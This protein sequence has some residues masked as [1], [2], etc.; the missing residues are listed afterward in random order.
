ME[1]ANPPDYRS[2]DLIE[3]AETDLQQEQ[4]YRTAGI[5]G[6]VAVLALGG[7]LVLLNS[8]NRVDLLPASSILA[9][10]LGPSD[11]MDLASGL[12]PSPQVLSYLRPLDTIYTTDSVYLEV[13]LTRQDVTVHQR[14][15]GSRSFLISSG[16]PFISEGMSTPT[17]IFTVQGMTPMAISKQ[18]NNARLHHWIG[19]QGGV[20]FHGLDGSGYYGYLGKRPSSHGCMRMSREEISD[21]FR[22]VHPG[23]LITVHYGEP[24][25]VIAF[26]DVGDTAGA[27]LIDS[28]SVFNRKLG[29]ER[30]KTLLDGRMWVD[31]QPRLVHLARQRL[32]WGMSMADARKIPKQQIP[33]RKSFGVMRQYLPSMEPDLSHTGISALHSGLARLQAD[34]I[35]AS[36]RDS[37]VAADHTEPEYGE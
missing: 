37:V 2:L 23:A 3:E 21:M 20:G 18:F 27:D 36:V 15:G 7:V 35:N 9:R 33:E 31:P 8:L 12:P 13:N 24:A 30:L 4:R 32:R 34:S 5:V 25:R 14:S 28:N 10:S 17:G 29:S 16:T 6:L 11:S 1:E 22:L 26:C 19:V